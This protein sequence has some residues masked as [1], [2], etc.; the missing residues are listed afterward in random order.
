MMKILTNE[1]EVIHSMRKRN[2]GCG[3]SWRASKHEKEG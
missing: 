2:E 1:S 3:K